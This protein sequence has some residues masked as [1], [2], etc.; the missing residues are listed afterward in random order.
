MIAGKSAAELQKLLD[1]VNAMRDADIAFRSEDGEHIKIPIAYPDPLE[2]QALADKAQALADN[3]WAGKEGRKI[4]TALAERMEKIYP[5]LVGGGITNYK[6]PVHKLSR[7]LNL[8]EWLDIDDVERRYFFRLALETYQDLR[9][10]CG[11]YCDGE[12]IPKFINSKN[13][14]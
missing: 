1:L 5:L 12:F 9:F 2:L 10:R 3:K 4:A 14:E 6:I 7:Y 13:G 8:L 11:I